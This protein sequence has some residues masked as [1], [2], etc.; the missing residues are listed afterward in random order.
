MMF[1]GKTS[2][3]LTSWG[4]P[5]KGV[6][7][8]VCDW[9]FLAPDDDAHKIKQRCPHCFQGDLE[10][11]NL[12]ISQL[13][14]QHSP[15]LVIV[16][17]VAMEIIAGKIG[18]FAD[19]IPFPPGDLRPETLRQR[20]QLVFLPQLLVDCSVSA[21]WN[22]E[23]GF[24]YAVLSHQEHFS[25]GGWTTQKVEE[26]RIRWEPRVGRLQRTYHNVAAPAMR[27]HADVWRRLGAYPIEQA[28][29]Y[30][31]EL[32]MHGLIRLPDLNP[33]TAWSGVVPLLHQHA[34]SEVKTATAAEHIRNF[35][36]APEYADKN[37]TL[38]L[39]PVYATFYTDDNGQPQPV[40]I[41]AQSGQVDGARRSSMKSA[42]RLSLILGGIAV[43]IFVLSLILG[44]VGMLFPPLLILG[45]L[46]IVVSA[47][48]GIGALFP[49][50]RS[51][52]FNLQNEKPGNRV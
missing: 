46:G 2:D 49:M 27:G 45:I 48:V 28:K 34:G 1:E 7:C 33:E 51:W 40:L 39:A 13:P 35:R 5:L 19:K 6:I 16:P 43:V 41:H 29:T 47:G 36:W 26:T 20:L 10:P 8:T 21:V 24:D 22:A 44:A 25:G 42:Q 38:F 31:P 17:S 30:S 4:I 15:E 52:R 37:W 23:S 18:E 11:S 3:Y 12:D 50:L 9:S 14:Y 32:V